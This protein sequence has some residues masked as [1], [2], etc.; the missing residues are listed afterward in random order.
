MDDTDKLEAA[1]E[2]LE[3]EKARRLQAKID[4]G[5]V[6]SVQTTVVVGPDEDEEKAKA[7]AIAKHPAPDDGRPIHRA[8]TFV[9][10]GVPRAP[11]HGNE[12]EENNS[13]QA[14]TRAS[15]EKGPSHPSTEEPAAS[16]LLTCLQP[17]YV[18]IVTS[19][20]SDDGDPGQIVEAW[21][22]IEDGLLTLRD[23]DDKYITSRA[24]L[25]GE[26]PAVL[27]RSLLR[28]VEKP[29]DF[30]RSIRYPKLGLA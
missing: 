7:R 4:A 13:P 19:N 20:G 15:S 28:E 26:A 14:Q 2:Q 17:T 9:H 21:Y 3:I 5:E 10:T 22:T 12:K 25:E 27:A 16:G 11:D 6:V 18:R 8:F 30:N 1:L 29:K 24:M 23:A